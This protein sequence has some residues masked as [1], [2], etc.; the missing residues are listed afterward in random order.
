MQAGKSHSL[1]LLSIVVA[2]RLSR[3]S[4]KMQMSFRLIKTPDVYSKKCDIGEVG[5]RRGCGESTLPKFTFILV[6]LLIPPTC[7]V[8]C[9][10]MFESATI[11]TA[12]CDGDCLRAACDADTVEA[13]AR[14]KLHS[15]VCSAG[16]AA[17][18]CSGQSVSC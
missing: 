10:Q 3:E 7:S 1:K 18:A 14:G 16:P 4:F 8:K 11:V 13:V 2:E 15:V 12:S 17:E 9:L 6:L 5:G